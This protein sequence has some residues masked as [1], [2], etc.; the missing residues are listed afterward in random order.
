VGGFLSGLDN[1]SKTLIDEF[2]KVYSGGQGLTG[3]SQLTSERAVADPTAALD[4][5]GLPFTPTNGL[6]QVQVYNTQTGERKTTDVRIDL[7]GL[8]TDA[9]LTDLAAQLDAIDGIGATITTDGKLQITADSPQT[10][11]AFAGD[12]SGT[13]AALGLNTFFSG[14]SA[15]DISVSQVVKDD[16]TTLAFSSDGVAEDTKN[17][18]LLA[19]LLTAPLSTQSGASL[20]DIYER[21]TSDVATG[22]QAASG[23]ADG[24]R[25][26]QQ[27]LESQ[28]LAVSGV[29]IDEEAV[30]MIEYQRAFQA[31][32][33]VISTVNELLDTLLKM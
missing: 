5:A 33:R 28:H 4:A 13:L 26:F 32:A 24:F 11:F 25:H 15:L 23:A 18:E 20:S 16:P 6:F 10:Q 2:N 8:G 7:T 19:N 30:R 12:T 29:N 22:S 21:L 9:T 17:G 27:A 14:S 3:Y 1:V 31:S